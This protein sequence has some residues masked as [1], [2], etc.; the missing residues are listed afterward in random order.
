MGPIPVTQHHSPVAARHTAPA[1]GGVAAADIAAKTTA[2]ADFQGV[3]VCW[4]R[5]HGNRFGSGSG[6]FFCFVQACLA[7][8]P[9]WD[10]SDFA[11]LCLCLFCVLFCFVFCFVLFCFVVVLF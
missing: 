6:G 2:I 1:R 8:V 10:G 5:F 11:F 7:A 9:V 3:C 4:V